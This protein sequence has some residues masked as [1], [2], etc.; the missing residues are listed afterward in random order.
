MLIHKYETVMR[1]YQGLNSGNSLTLTI[2]KQG[3]VC[4]SFILWTGAVADNTSTLNEILVPEEYRPRMDVV[5]STPAITSG[6]ILSRGATRITL[7]K[8]GKVSF[9]TDEKQYVERLVSFTY[10][11]NDIQH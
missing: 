6:T 4:F 10:I 3:N 11:V 2:I 9:V 1:P 8:D 5:A 7:G